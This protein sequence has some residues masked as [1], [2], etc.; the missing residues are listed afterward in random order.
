M[1]PGLGAHEIRDVG[2]GHRLALDED[3]VRMAAVSTTSFIC[4]PRL[5]EECDPPSECR[6][7]KEH[8]LAVDEFNAQN[9]TSNPPMR[10]AMRQTP[11]SFAMSRR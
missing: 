9:G 2:P 4:V 8:L 5:M 1:L 10:R 3:R 11:A 6:S 7:T